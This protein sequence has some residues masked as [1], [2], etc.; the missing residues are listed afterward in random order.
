MIRSTLRVRVPKPHRGEIGA[1]LLAH[2]LRETGMER[3][4]WEA[5]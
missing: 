5:L 2:I 4:D 3:E 1:D